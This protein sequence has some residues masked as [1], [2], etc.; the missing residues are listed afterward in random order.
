MIRTYHLHG[1]LGY[2]NVFLFFLCVIL[3][4]FLIRMGLGMFGVEW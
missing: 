3:L 1:V 2:D 4:L